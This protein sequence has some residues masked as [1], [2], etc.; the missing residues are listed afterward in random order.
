MKRCLII[1][2]AVL[3]PAIIIS[4]IVFVLSARHAGFAIKMPSQVTKP[5][6][7]PPVC[8]GRKT[9]DKPFLGVAENNP[10]VDKQRL[11]RFTGLS[12]D[13]VAFY[14]AFGTPYDEKTVC[15]IG[16]TAIPL[17]QWNPRKVPISAIISGKYDQYLRRYARN[18]ARYQAPVILSFGHEMNGPWYPWGAGHVKPADFVKAWR[19]IHTEMREATNVIWMWNPNHLTNSAKSLEDWYPGNAY[20][21]L[22]G[23]DGYYRG[24]LETFNRLFGPSLIELNRIAPHKPVILAEVGVSPVGYFTNKVNDLFREAKAWSLAGVI[25]FD[26]DAKRQWSM[27]IPRGIVIRKAICSEHPSLCRN[28]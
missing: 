9:I 27:N 13:V 25:W 24:P 28:R 20:T 19:R 11:H 22:I 10:T 14:T 18:L 15:G 26:I 4:G 8:H 23:L 21:D 3:V 1:A 16:K 17:I 7:P 2:V 6:P 5:T 12:P